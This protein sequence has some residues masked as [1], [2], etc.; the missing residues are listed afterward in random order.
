MQRNVFQVVEGKCTEFIGNRKSKTKRFIHRVTLTGLVP[1]NTYQYR[2][3]SEY[4]WSALY[5]FT[6]MTPRSDGG[7]E[8]AV[9]GDLGNQNARSLAKLQRLAQDGDIDMVLHVGDFAYN[10]DTDD[11]EVGDEFFR[12]LEP[13]AAYV[14]YMAAVGSVQLHTLCQPLHNA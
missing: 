11:G 5:K 1:G 7:Y 14:P 13:V 9:F 10:L 12:Q 6:A 8:I 3:G 4:G 2:V